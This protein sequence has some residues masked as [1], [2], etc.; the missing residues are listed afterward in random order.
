MSRR[1]PFAWN[2]YA[3]QPHNV[4]PRSERTRH[5]LRHWRSYFPLVGSNLIHGLPALPAYRR[6][7]KR[8]YRVPVRIEPGMFGVS[9]SPPP[10]GREDEVVALLKE[11]GAS[12]TLVRAASWEREK[13]PDLERFAARLRGEGFEVDVAV[14]QRRR[15]VLEPEGW[16]DFLEEV[17]ARLSSGPTAFEIGHAWNRTKW[18]VWDYTE[19][20]ELAKAAFDLRPKFGVRLAG[21]AVID[22]EFHLY[23]PTLRKL[24]FDAVTSLLYV[25]RV[26][27]PENPQFGWTGPMKIA[28]FKAVADK[29]AGRPRPCWISEVN[30]PLQGTG[31]YSPASGR[32]NVTEGEQADFLVRYY[33]LALAGGL[34]E[35]VY[36]WQL[37]APGYGLVDSRE[38]LW[39]A[40]PAHAALR[41]LV[42]MVAGSTFT[43]ATIEDAAHVFRFEK[44]GRRFAVC[45]TTGRPVERAWSEP[46]AELIGRD[47]NR[48]E[49]SGPGLTLEGS[50]KYVFSGL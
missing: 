17:F 36:W 13:L 18:G 50:P 40:R 28:L 32:P 30:W 21:P 14:L 26:G 6:N 33:L 16:R 24:P 4:A 5:H 29:S 35:R 42:G 44:E 48:L 43:G 45:W 23:P 38:A 10:H 31:P 19:Y 1:F 12:R 2:P 25:D 27:A 11:T 39:R 34:I 49:P 7:M 9:V 20:L 47:G 37:V 41:T 8:M 3:D 15:D 22:F 46:I